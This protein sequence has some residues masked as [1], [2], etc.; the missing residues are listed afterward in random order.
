VASVPGLGGAPRY[1]MP[2]RA[3]FWHEDCKA[4]RYRICSRQDPESC[5]LFFQKEGEGEAHVCYTPTDSFPSVSRDD[6]K[7]SFQRW[8]LAEMAERTKGRDHLKLVLLFSI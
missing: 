5:S 8:R 7:H 1:S 4:A 3:A 6:V 2:F